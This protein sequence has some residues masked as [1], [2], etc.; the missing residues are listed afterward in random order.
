MKKLVI[1]K[2]VLWLVKFIGKDVDGFYSW[3]FDKFSD[4]ILDLYKQTS[5]DQAGDQVKGDK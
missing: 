3:D 2:L 4:S 1:I 5:S